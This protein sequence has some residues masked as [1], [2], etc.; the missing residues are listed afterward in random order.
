MEIKVLELNR[1]INLE[2]LFRRLGVE[3]GGIKIMREKELGRIFYIEGLSCGAANILKQDLLSLGGE[4][5]VPKGVPNCSRKWTPAVLMVT[6]RQLRQLIQKERTQPFN[7]KELAEKLEGFLDFP[8]FPLQ[9][10]GVVNLNQDSF[11]A[12][13]RFSG[14]EG[15]RQIERLIEEGADIIDIGGVSS[16]PGSRYPGEE[17]ELR[18]VAPIL[19]E[20]GKRGLWRYVKFSLDT[21]SPKVL[22]FGLERGVQIANDITGGERWEYLELVASYNAQL[23]IMHKKGTPETMQQNPYYRNVLIEVDQ[24]F[25]ERIARARRAGVEKIILDVGIGFGKRMVD[26]LL[27]IR[28]LG[29]FRRFR[30]PLLLGVSRKSIIATVEEGAN[31]PPSPPE[32]R[33]PGTLA[34]HLEGV[35]N[36]ASILRVHDLKAHRQALLLWDAL[37]EQESNWEFQ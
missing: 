6:T 19:E 16:R 26:N 9:L 35:K 8:T 33:L 30:Y 20:I 31:L 17:E 32:G 27:L 7:L 10:M 2:R 5:A 24:F 28:H 13:S 4:L 18:R 25:Q 11:Y 14:E 21:F 34:L 37:R 29:H 22:K 12:G 36:G 1:E 15:V 23:V 3:K